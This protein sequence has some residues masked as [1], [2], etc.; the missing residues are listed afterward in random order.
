MWP[1]RMPPE[2]DRRHSSH[3]I[4]L[5]QPLEEVQESVDRPVPKRTSKTEIFTDRYH[6]RILQQGIFL[7]MQEFPV[8]SHSWIADFSGPIRTPTR[9]LNGGV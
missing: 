1:G 2:F 6:W 9:E 4:R 7:K 8:V 3:K 5:K